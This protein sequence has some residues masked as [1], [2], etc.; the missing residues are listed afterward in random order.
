MVLT[1]LPRVISCTSYSVTTELT[2]HAE[3]S[4]SYFPDILEGRLRRGFSE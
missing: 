3:F 1:A 2:A 4:L